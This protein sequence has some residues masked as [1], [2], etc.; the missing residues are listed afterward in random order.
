M[1]YSLTRHGHAC[2]HSRRPCRRR[3]GCIFERSRR[4]RSARVAFYSRH[5]CNSSRAI[6]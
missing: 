5:S 3:P 2:N 4:Q 6:Q 1:C